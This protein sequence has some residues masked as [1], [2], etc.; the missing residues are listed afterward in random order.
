LISQPGHAIVVMGASVG[1]VGALRAVLAQLPVDIPAAVFVVMHLAPQSPGLLPR[2]LGHVSRLKVAAARDREAIELGRVYVAPADCHLL[3]SNGQVR[4]VHGPKENRFRPAI[5]PLFRSAAAYYRSR[6]IGVVLTGYLDDGT[7]GLSAIKRCGG[8]AVVQD[9]FD[10]LAPEMP[11]NALDEVPVDHIVPLAEIGALLDRLARQPA[12]EPPPVPEEIRLEV[13]IMERGQSDVATAQELG[14]PS[15]YSCP[16]CGGTLVEVPD[17]PAPRFR[18][19]VGHAFTMQSL[20]A[21]Q[22]NQIEHSIWAAVRALEERASLLKRMAQ[23]SI[24]RAHNTSADDFQQQSAESQEHAEKLRKLLLAA[25]DRAEP[26]P[27]A[28]S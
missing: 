25:V 16:E 17:D 7:A 13:A 26:L 19:Q 15:V 12:A 3:L 20:L 2:L 10:A 4:V 8:R 27:E 24:R 21:D 28:G 5:D 11:Q 22:S 23:H 1:G 9:P 14:K 18:C 6:T